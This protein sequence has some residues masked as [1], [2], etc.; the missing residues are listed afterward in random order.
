MEATGAA[1]ALSATEQRKREKKDKNAPPPDPVA[2]EVLKA[3]AAAKCAEQFKVR[4]ADAC[5]VKQGAGGHQRREVQGTPWVW[6]QAAGGMTS[7]AK[8]GWCSG[9]DELGAAC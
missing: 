8:G 2:V 5:V 9:L 3:Q 6:G 4:G 1:G 7:D